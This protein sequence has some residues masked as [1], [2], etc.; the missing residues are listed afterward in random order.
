MITK[1]D[2]GIIAFPVDKPG[3]LPDDTKAGNVPFS[4]LVDILWS[5]YQSI[6][7]ITGNRQRVL[8]KKDEGLHIFEIKHRGGIFNYILTQFRLSWQVFRLSRKVS[9]WIFFIGAEALAFPALTARLAG[10]PIFLALTGFPA[11]IS[12]EE[13]TRRYQIVDFLS[14]TTLKLATRIIAYSPKIIEERNLQRFQRKI[15][16]AQEHFLD[17]KNFK[18]LK[19]LSRRNNV[20]AYIGRLSEGKGISNLLVAISRIAASRSDVRFLIGG[21]GPL[22]SQ[23]EEYVNRPHLKDRISYI[24]WI[25]Y[26]NLPEYLNTVK[27]LVLPSYTEAL[28][29]IILEAMACGTPVLTTSVGAIPDIIKESETGFILESNSSDQIAIDV[30]RVLD[31]PKLER[32]AVSARKLVKS[33]YT[34][35]AAVEKY[36]EIMASLPA[37][38]KL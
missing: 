13:R 27:V 20:V 8:F 24:G 6:Y 7:V 37:G 22:R 17:F 23:V 25:N 19:P 26:E 3:G 5:M 15:Q 18:I 11:K 9:A 29:N 31:S 30:V 28:P 34:Y 38:G 2:I 32:V 1:H 36:R 16:F 14:E 21:D 4:H 35:P 10:K 12:T 33:Q